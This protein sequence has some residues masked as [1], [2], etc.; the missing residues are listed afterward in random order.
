MPHW[1]RGASVSIERPR[2]D[3]LA[4]GGARRQGPAQLVATHTCAYEE[5]GPGTSVSR[6]GARGVQEFFSAG[7][8][9]VHGAPLAGSGHRPV[10]PPCSLRRRREPRLRPSPRGVG[11]RHHHVAPATPSHGRRLRPTAF[12]AAGPAFPGASAV[13]VAVAVA[14]GRKYQL[15]GHVR[16]RSVEDL[17]RSPAATR[18]FEPPSPALRRHGPE[19]AHEAPGGRRARCLQRL[20]GSLKPTHSRSSASGRSHDH[21]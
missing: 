12:P 2:A 6:D 4:A 14:V 16:L 7:G 21:R 9:V 19:G 20:G 17:H 11:P 15:S 1:P 8:D 10:S 5:A 18:C 13:A 3:R